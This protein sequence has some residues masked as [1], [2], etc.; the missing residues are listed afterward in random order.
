[1]GGYH[2]VDRSRFCSLPIAHSSRSLWMRV[3]RGP[4]H[5]RCLSPP[6]IRCG[7]V[8]E[9]TARMR[10]SLWVGSGTGRGGMI[11]HTTRLHHS[12]LTT[13]SLDRFVLLILLCE[14]NSAAPFICPLRQ[15]P[16]H[17]VPSCSSC[18]TGV[19]DGMRSS[20]VVPSDD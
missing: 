20:H 13:I 17:L 2:S 7:F 14:V 16:P 15:C 6:W 5:E 19:V 18:P 3:A 9:H 8:V 12:S 11:S 10:I 4:Q 1:M